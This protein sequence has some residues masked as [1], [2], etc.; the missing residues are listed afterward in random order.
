[1]IEAELFD[2]TV[3]EFPDGTS[4]AVIDQAVKRETAARRLAPKAPGGWQREGTGEGFDF[5]R[6]Q[7]VAAMAPI[8]SMTGGLPFVGT[9]DDEVVGAVAGPDA[10]REFQDARAVMQ[11][12]APGVDTAM[13]L[14]SGVVGSAGLAMLP[15][16]LASAGGS[17]PVVGGL[18]SLPA[19]VANSAARAFSGASRAG[20]IGSAI[21]GG[22]LAGGLEGAIAGYGIDER[23]TRAQNAR[24]MGGFGAALGGGMAGVATAA[25]PLVSRAANAI[26][27]A[28]QSSRPARIP[29]LSREAS[30]QIMLRAQADDIGGAGVAAIRNAGP[31]GMIA[32]AGPAMQSLTDQAVNMS[33][34]GARI[35][36]DAVTQ[37]AAGSA[38]DLARTFDDVMGGPEGIATLQTRIRDAARP[39]INQ[40]Y[41]TA[42]STPIDYASDAGRSLEE[43]M[44]R[45]P[46]RTTLAAIEKANARM[47]FD[48]MPQMQIIAEIADNG[49]VTFREMPNVMQWDYIKRG[50][51]GIATD[52]TDAITG[53]MTDDAAFASKIAGEVKSRLGNAVPSYLNAVGEA[54]DEFALQ[55]ATTLGESILSRGTKRDAV[56]DWLNGA[57]DLERKAAIAALRSDIDERMANAT[58][59]AGSEEGIKE[60]RTIFRDMSSPAA[61]TKVT[62]LLGDA[63]AKRIFEA[64]DRAEASLQMLSGVARN[65]PTAPRLVGDAQL[66]TSREYSPGEIAREA[67]SGGVLTAARRV[68]DIAAANTPMD[69]VLRD[70]ELYREIARYLTQARGSQ[71][72]QAAQDMAQMLQYLPGRRAATAA[73]GR[74]APGALGLLGYQSVSQ[75]LRAPASIPQR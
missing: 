48:G 58:R 36:G 5:D 39:G 30:D 29:G 41:R 47:V 20:Q 64:L 27:D 62:A 14:G 35:A 74:V 17:L 33:P 9:Y 26:A 54:A 7:R 10:R 23:G 61:R 51:S 72:V 49:T 19:R 46:A 15:G 43:L 42:Y 3:L 45:L 67:A 44:G 1:M 66:R 40:A 4:Q 37:R 71:A 34:S 65:S 59:I 57:G 53:R 73:I 13:R 12:T 75:D 21:G 52:G 16:A 22:A 56:V 24:E 18:L 60:A 55:R 50:F 38:D 25:A 32:D 31:N 68:G 28:M 70:E 8:T 69:R 63:E 6:A 2:G 11:Q